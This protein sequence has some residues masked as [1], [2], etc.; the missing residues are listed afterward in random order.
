M[1]EI[2]VLQP[3]DK[4]LTE[5][6][7]AV[8]TKHHHEKKAKEVLVHKGFD[9]L[10]PL[11]EALHKWKDRNKKISLPVFP[12]YLFLRTN[13]DRKREILTTPGVFWLVENAGRA[14]PIPESD[15]DAI[16]KIIRNGVPVEP[17][18]YLKCGEFVRV[19]TGPLTGIRGILTR[20]KNR[21]RVVLSVEL[22]QKSIAVEVDATMVEPSPVFRSNSSR[23]MAENSI[24]GWPARMDTKSQASQ[25]Q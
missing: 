16:G 17:H 14:C 11:Y 4:I 25:K 19:R 5:A 12:C 7:Y 3:P 21:C 2:D 10:L 22:L 15:I 1:P 8:Y 13:L 6:W 9:V 18:P 20:I 24:V 23:E